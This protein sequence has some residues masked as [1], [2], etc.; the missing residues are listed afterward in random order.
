M[1]PSIQSYN[2]IAHAAQQALFF[3]SLFSGS[4][5]IQLLM[6]NEFLSVEGKKNKKHL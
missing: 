6:M 2:T 4:T 1:H 3:L 5:L